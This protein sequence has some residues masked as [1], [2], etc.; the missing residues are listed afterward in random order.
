MAEREGCMMKRRCRGTETQ[1]EKEE[2]EKEEE[3]EAG[4]RN[5][6]MNYRVEVGDELG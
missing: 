3:D 2:E 6:S 5:L 4:W 1:E